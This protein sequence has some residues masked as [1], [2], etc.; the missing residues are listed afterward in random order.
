MKLFRRWWKKKRKAE[1][2]QSISKEIGALLLL[3][4]KTR[5]PPKLRM[6]LGHRIHTLMLIVWRHALL[7]T[8]NPYHSAPSLYLHFPSAHCCSAPLLYFVQ[9][10]QES[11]IR[12]CSEW[13]LVTERCLWWFYTRQWK[14]DRATDAE[15]VFVSLENEIHLDRGFSC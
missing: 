8:G 9:P 6:D 5:W 1:L 14:E 13:C 4:F 12:C 10:K 2:F 15:E 11:S 7:R 3:I